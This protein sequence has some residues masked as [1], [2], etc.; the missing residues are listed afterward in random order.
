MCVKESFWGGGFWNYVMR[1]FELNVLILKS[2]VLFTEELAL[3]LFQELKKMW[4]S[5]YLM[6]CFAL[7]ALHWG[8]FSFSQQIMRWWL[9]VQCQKITHISK[10]Y[11]VYDSALTCVCACVRTCVCVRVMCCQVSERTADS[12]CSLDVVS[13]SP[14]VS[15]R[16]VAHGFKN[17]SRKKT[18]SKC[19]LHLKLSFDFILQDTNLM[20]FVQRK[21]AHL[22]IA[23]LY[24]QP[25][26]CLLFPSQK[27]NENNLFSSVKSSRRICC[28][29]VKSFA[30]IQI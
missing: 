6:I 20:A 4:S 27:N 1:S 22:Q 17:R 24:N 18:H 12:F 11:F 7:H 16:V 2:K 19:Q 9:L 29:C 28:F 14:F 8:N 25:K 15:C 3:V 13:S 23:D 30:K 5:S 21:C 26:S 10:D